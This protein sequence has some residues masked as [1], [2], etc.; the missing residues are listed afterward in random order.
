MS[1]ANDPHAVGRLLRAGSRLEEAEGVVILLHGRGG[2]ADDIL[3]LHIGL[4]A[5]LGD[6]KIAWLAPEAEGRTWYPSTFLAPRDENEPYLSSA[7]LRVESLVQAAAKA[8][9]GPDRIVF[10]GFSQGACLATEFVASHP[11]PYAGLVSWTGALSGPL[12]THFDYQGDL[13]RMPAL[14]LSGDPDPYIPWSRVEESAAVL[15]R[16]NAEVNLQRYPGRA[17]MIS[18]DELLL[19]CDLIERV[20]PGGRGRP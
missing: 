7:L 1:P 17:H 13:G 19:A 16:M 9:L 3:S 4:E 10:G 20:F 2:S 11:A 8:G 14:L 6:R 18:Q 5:G 15:R 12:G